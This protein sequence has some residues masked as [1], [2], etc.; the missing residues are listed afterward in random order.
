MDTNKSFL[1]RARE[2]CFAN[3]YFV[4]GSLDALPFKN[5][6]FDNL[7]CIDAIEHLPP[8]ASYNTLSE[9]ERVVK[10]SGSLL[11]TTPN[12][13]FFTK[14][15]W[16]LLARVLGYY[17]DRP[18]DNLPET[19]HLSFYTV[20][21]F[22]KLGFRVRGYLGWVTKRYLRSEKLQRILDQVFWYLP[23]LSGSLIATKTINGKKDKIGVR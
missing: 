21:D 22:K 8:S 9:F 3:A 4:V 23:W 2:R 6:A 1:L 12:V 18:K 13:N 14:T 19:Y 7:V 15:M 20:S 17:H 11:I 5:Q 16:F 10:T